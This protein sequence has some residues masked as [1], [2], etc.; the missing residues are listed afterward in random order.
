MNG[1]R[2]L[3]AGWVNSPH[4]AAWADAVLE[5]GCEVHVAGQL[6]ERWP[7][8][9]EPERFASL[10]VLDPG[11][12]PGMRDR[13]LGRALAREAR[14]IRPDLVHAHWAPGY[15]WMAARAGLRPLVTS[16]WGSD[17]LAASRRLTWRSRRA[18]RASDLVLADSAPLADAARRLAGPGVPVEIVQWGVDL[19]RFR[20]DPEARAAARR[21]LGVDGSP[22]VL[23]TRALDGIYNPGILLEAF[24]LLRRRV[25]E[26]RLVLKHPGASLP[27]AIE[28]R[29]EELGLR[30]ATHAVGFLDDDA[31]ARL[32]RAAD[33]YVS[34]PSTDSSPRS[35]WEALACGTP[36]VVSDLPW[37]RAALCDGEHALLVPVDA[38]AVAGALERL[39]IEPGVA[40]AIG[41]NGFALTVATMNR[42]D[43][44]A[45]L[46]AL[47]RGVLG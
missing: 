17:L 5:L 45:R 31:L 44:L 32:Y 7:A 42:R 12:V 30:G 20:P 34:I 29:I 33:A 41:R 35:V 21:E 24:S 38:R 23:S 47:Y 3:V 28:A 40:A 2:V 6:V 39:L 46:E 22:V 43:H 1:T 11:S 9:Q 27:P 13:R 18:L 14:R 16:A 15:G 8:P 36:A 26:A 4:V 10:T 25:P 19:D 37:A